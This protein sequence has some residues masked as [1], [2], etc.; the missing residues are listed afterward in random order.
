MKGIFMEIIIFIAILF[1]LCSPY[2]LKLEKK[3]LRNKN[4]AEA[5]KQEVTPQEPI[6]TVYYPYKKKFLLTKTEYN[7]HKI[8]QEECSRNN[9]LICP[10]V[11]MEDFLEVTD[12]NDYMK[13]RGYIKSRHIDF[14]ICDK[15]LHILCG[16]E[17]DDN[18]HNTEKAQKTDSFKD[19]VFKAIDIPLFRI[20]VS[21]GAYRIKIVNI[22]NAL[23]I[24][25]TPT[26]K[27]TPTE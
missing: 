20:K 12:K 14:I 25:D 1:L 7:F 8:L 16:I 19:N 3:Y 21:D 18:S 22:I 6:E 10:K 15:D 17:L 9:L 24:D 4:K 11:R 2:L 13:Y 23:I 27:P 5:P 26:E